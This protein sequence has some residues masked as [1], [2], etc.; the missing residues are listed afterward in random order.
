MSV[1]PEESEGNA[2]VQLGAGPNPQLHGYSRGRASIVRPMGEW[3]IL[4]TSA[5]L[6]SAPL[7]RTI[8]GLPIVLFR[9]GEGRASALLDRCPHRNVPLSLGEV[10]NGQLQCAY[11]GWRFD[12]TGACRF[13]PS[14]KGEVEARS[15]NVPSFPVQ[16]LD[17]FIWVLPTAG[18]EPKTEPYRFRHIGERGYT[19]ERR[20]HRAG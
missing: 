13:I 5:E 15:R 1:E 17:G 4:A 3:Y 16:E 2:F 11:H 20:V 14:L 6:G 7:E 12:G 10:A 9:D 18:A 8:F 19:V